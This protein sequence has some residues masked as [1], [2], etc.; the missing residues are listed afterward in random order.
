L[1]IRNSCPVCD[2]REGFGSNIE[3][4]ILYQDAPVVYKTIQELAVDPAN[5]KGQLFER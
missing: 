3:I 5:K 1:P 4:T 2:W